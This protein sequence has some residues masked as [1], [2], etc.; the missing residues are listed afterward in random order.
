[1]LLCRVGRFHPDADGAV[2][3]LLLAGSL[4]ISNR[5]G[6]AKLGKKETAAANGL[7]LHTKQEVSARAGVCA[8]LLG[9]DSNYANLAHHHHH[10][11]HH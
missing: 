7:R 1:M 10:Y 11:H 8:A 6:C 5:I 9:A 3:H 2:R 4:A